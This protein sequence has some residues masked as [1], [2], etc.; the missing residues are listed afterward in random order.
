[1]ESSNYLNYGCLNKLPF[2]GK[3]K[4]KRRKVKTK[5]KME[6][7]SSLKRNTIHTKLYKMLLVALA[8]WCPVQET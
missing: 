1:M 5:K 6:D 2:K 8:D 4:Y 7:N 3:K